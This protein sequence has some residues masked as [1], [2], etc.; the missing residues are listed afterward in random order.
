MGTDKKP[1]TQSRL[2]TLEHGLAAVQ[3]AVGKLDAKRA[4]HAQLLSTI[5]AVTENIPDADALR[6]A[7]SARDVVAGLQRAHDQLEQRVAGIGLDAA[8]GMGKL[9]QHVEETERRMQTLLAQLRAGVGELPPNTGRPAPADYQLGRA[10]E[11]AALAM[12]RLERLE[13]RF[14]ELLD[15]IGFLQRKGGENAGAVQVL[16]GQLSLF[17]MRAAPPEGEAG[18]DPRELA[19]RIRELLGSYAARDVP[20]DLAGELAELA[21]DIE[22]GRVR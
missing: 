6:E 4:E 19:A 3:A 7:G 9:E 14:D 17:T 16:T 1:T 21:A 8:G 5:L 12:H 13:D 11:T 2:E 18:T 22:A 20:R 10:T 15:T